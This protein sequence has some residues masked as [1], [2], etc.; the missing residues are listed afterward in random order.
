M[1]V[2]I[3]DFIVYNVFKLFY[4]FLSKSLVNEDNSIFGFKWI[5]FSTGSEDEFKS[6]TDQV[7]KDFRG[8]G[9]KL[10]LDK[11]VSLSSFKFETFIEGLA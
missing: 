7:C 1:G 6:L 8:I 9:F 5:V 10:L 3:Y 2:K 11:R 4:W